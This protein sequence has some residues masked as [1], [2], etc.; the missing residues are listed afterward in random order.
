MT[1]DRSS[2][3]GEKP[4][5]ENGP[6]G[7]DAETK[8]FDEL[9]ATR[10]TADRSGDDS[11]AGAE[12]DPPTDLETDSA[13]AD[14]PD[15][16][17]TRLAENKPPEGLSDKQRGKGSAEQRTVALDPGHFGSDSGNDSGT[18]EDADATRVVGSG[19]TDRAMA[20]TEVLGDPPWVHRTR[21]SGIE[22]SAWMMPA[23]LR[24]GAAGRPGRA[25]PRPC[26]PGRARPD[27]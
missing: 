7:D 3:K 18:A 17:R 14:G 20:G 24:A 25:R 19:D 11:D 22:P 10:V 27:R 8:P 13:E 15:L 9:A 2:K 21:R 26:P 5:I 23:S 4:E 6:A 12:F 16:D 1:Q